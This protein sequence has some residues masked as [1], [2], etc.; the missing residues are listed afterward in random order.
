[1]FMNIFM[2]TIKRVTAKETTAAETFLTAYSK[3]QTAAPQKNK[4]TKSPYKLTFLKQK[5]EL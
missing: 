4:K 3:F 1:M 2:D 5:S